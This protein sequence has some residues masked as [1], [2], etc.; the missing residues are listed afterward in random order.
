MP[1]VII[2]LIYILRRC[3]AKRDHFAHI[4]SK[5][6]RVKSSG[7][8]GNVSD[9]DP[10]NPLRTQIEH[11]LK[12][13]SIYAHRELFNTEV[14]ISD[15]TLTREVLQRCP[16]RPVSHNVLKFLFGTNSIFLVRDGDWHKLRTKLETV[17]RRV[18][19][20][21]FLPITIQCTQDFIS[22]W[23][24][25]TPS[26]SVDMDKE[27][28]QLS[29]TVIA[30]T[31]FSR[32]SLS[33]VIDHVNGLI[34]AVTR[35]LGN[36][37][38]LLDLRNPYQIYKCQHEIRQYFRK[39]LQQHKAVEGKTDMVTSLVDYDP[40]TIVDQLMSF[41]YAGHDTVGHTLAWTLYEVS[42][43]P[44]VEAK[45]LKEVDSVKEVNRETI[46]NVEGGLKYLNAVI[47][48]VLRLHP[49]A[50]VQDR[51]VPEDMDIGGYHFT[52]GTDIR[53]NLWSMHLNEKYW[54][55]PHRFDPDR[56]ENSSGVDPSWLPFN[57]GPRVCIGRDFAMQELR[58][59][60][61]LIYKTF[62]FTH[63]T[64]HVVGPE[65]KFTTLPTEGLYLWMRKR[66]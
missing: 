60:L 5:I 4:D 28:I 32:E 48:E 59:A 66:V 12:Y 46:G 24:T 31:L 50:S 61:C 58:V 62:T 14:Q 53:I 40:E 25:F 65:S 20:D 39:V 17:F 6:P 26:A 23:R 36:P 56:W 64:L 41:F 55:N 34:N 30:R 33:G 49:P 52:K 57:T 11:T 3:A 13:G 15:P 19:L 45:I 44:D 29:V 8:W 7:I 42:M 54:P 35:V 22:K 2:S 37:A 21:S 27:L 63:D 9:W 10:R 43:R 18:N 38:R 1:L 16:N 47:R 51:E